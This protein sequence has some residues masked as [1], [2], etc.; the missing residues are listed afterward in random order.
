MAK[1]Q[2]SGEIDWNAAD[3][4]GSKSKTDFLR[5]TE[6]ETTVRIMGKPIQCFVHW[7]KLPDGSNRKVTSPNDNPALVKRLEEAGFRKQPAWFLK[8]LDRTSSDESKHEFKLLEIGKQIY[9]GIL[10]YVN[11]KQYGNVTGYDVVLARGPKG[12]MP[13]YKVMA[14]PPEALDSAFKTRFAEFNEKLSMDKLIAP[15]PAGE[16]E[17]L[18]GWGSS[19]DSGN[20]KTASGSKAK[21]MEYDFE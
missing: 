12:Q 1:E 11:K 16:I 6:G 4:G 19:D 7:L 15:M 10:V 21:T 9:D 13:L 3:L 17:K 18:L 14:M 8:V 20:S 2:I 5:L